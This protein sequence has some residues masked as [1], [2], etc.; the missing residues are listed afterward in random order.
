M[1]QL[2]LLWPEGA[3]TK[4][5]LIPAE[6][7]RDLELEAIVAA[8]CPPLGHSYATHIATCYGVSYEQLRQ[9]AAQRKLLPE[10]RGGYE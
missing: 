6:T 1:T 4:T 8:F 10:K 2:S 3:P 7:I 5:W 9:L